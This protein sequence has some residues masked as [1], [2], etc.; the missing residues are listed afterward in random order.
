MRRHPRNWSR[1][2]RHGH[3][4]HD[5]RRWRSHREALGGIASRHHGRALRSFAPLRRQGAVRGVADLRGNCTGCARHEHR[6]PLRGISDRTGCASMSMLATGWAPMRGIAEVDGP[7]RSRRAERCVLGR[8]A[9]RWRGRGGCEGNVCG[10]QTAGRG[11]PRRQLLTHR[12]TLRSIAASAPTDLGPLRS[13]W[14]SLGGITR[15]KR[16]A[17][18]GIT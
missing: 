4:S 2:R 1:G 11:L 17:L 12:V 6:G 18:R 15:G 3:P 8:F 13:G 10:G 7:A 5:R 14:C 16:A 9:R